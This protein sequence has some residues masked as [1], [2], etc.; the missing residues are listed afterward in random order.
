M[1]KST[2]AAC[3]VL[4]GVLFLFMTGN[5]AGLP[6]LSEKQIKQLEKGDLVKIHAGKKKSGGYLGGKSFILLEDDLDT[7]HRVMVDIKNYYFFYDDTLIET[8]IV[9]KEKNTRIIKMVYG[10]GPVKMTYYARY[11]LNKKKHFIKFRLAEEYDNDMKKA[12]GYIKFTPYEDGRTLMTNVSL[13]KFEDKL[14]WKVFGKKIA[15][16]MLK[17]PKYLKKFLATPKSKKYRLAR[18]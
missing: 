14:I 10:K 11:T 3:L 9:K 6:K 17:L 16:G 7:C 4:A 18:N 13:V 15:N 8:K 5:A 2:I 12:L 1:K